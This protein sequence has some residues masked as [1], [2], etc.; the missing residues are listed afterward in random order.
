MIDWDERMERGLNRGLGWGLEGALLTT[1]RMIPSTG[2]EGLDMARPERMDTSIIPFWECRGSFFFFF[3]W[4]RWCLSLSRF[5]FS[6]FFLLGFF[7]VYVGHVYDLLMRVLYDSGA[8][9]TLDGSGL[10]NGNWNGKTMVRLQGYGGRGRQ[11]VQQDC[12]G[13]GKEHP[14]CNYGINAF[15]CYILPNFIVL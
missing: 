9:F 4:L 7:T 8:C 15:T 11:I 2:M 1:R 12:R 6:L 13:S 3:F 10:G 5:L 14:W